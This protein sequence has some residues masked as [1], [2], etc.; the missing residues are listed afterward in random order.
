[1]IMIMLQSDPS[2]RPKI[3]QLRK[4]DFIT[5]GYCP[6]SLPI[7]CLTMAPRFD[8][9]HDI[10]NHKTVLMEI[11]N[12][13]NG[14]SPRKHDSIAA[15]LTGVKTLRNSF[16]A[17]ENLQA[18]KNL[19][20]KVI[21]S[22]PTLH[23]KVSDEM[24][25]P[26]AQPTVWISKWVDYSDKYG[27]GYQLSDESVG[28][29]FNDTTR[30]VMLS[31]AINVQYVDKNGDESYMTIDTYPKEYEKKMKLLSYFSRYMREHLI[32]T[33]AG[34]V[35]ELDT[36][37]RTPHLHQWCRSTSG[38]L[39]QLNSGTLQMNFSDHTKII[40]C[41]LMAAITYID[42]DKSFMTFRFSTIEKY[43]CS[44]GL[45][46]KMKYAYDKISIL[47]ESECFK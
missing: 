42:E 43:G 12:N 6:S 30:L 4:H 21:K 7:S 1:M 41:P 34:V 37:S 17:K 15:G 10:T 35:K 29:M 32:K 47:L 24:T 8:N 18:L 26:V 36:M 22:N 25:D 33:G 44:K 11:H 9:V 19:L 23:K 14:I 16:D 28:V 45:L 39:M 2:R 20:I 13:T 46:E 31:N 5:N 38:V 3:E 27:F 40:M